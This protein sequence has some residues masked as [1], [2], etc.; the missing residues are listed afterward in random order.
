[1]TIKTFVCLRQESTNEI[2]D[3]VEVT[4]PAEDQDRFVDNDDIKRALSQLIDRSILCVGD[5]I[6]IEEFNADK[7]R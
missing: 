1:M 6:T 2:L 4:P 5:T 7:K 3:Q